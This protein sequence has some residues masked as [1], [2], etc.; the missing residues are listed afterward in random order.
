MKTKI[1][2]VSI[3]LIVFM[4]FL[5]KI[6]YFEQKNE[7]QLLNPKSTESN[8]SQSIP[9]NDN[10]EHNIKSSNKGKVLSKS[11]NRQ[12]VVDQTLKQFNS[13]L[14]DENFKQAGVVIEI[15]LMDGATNLFLPNYPVLLEYTYDNFEPESQTTTI[16]SLVTDSSGK[17][18]FTTNKIGKLKIALLTKDYALFYKNI[19]AG[20]GKNESKIKLYKGGT[21]EI[22]AVNE[23][24]EVINNLCIIPQDWV[25]VPQDSSQNTLVK[26]FNPLTFDSQKG[27]YT[28]TN[29]LGTNNVIFEAEGYIPSGLYQISVLANEKSFLE[30]KLQRPRKILLDFDLVDKPNQIKVFACTNVRNFDGKE[31]TQKEESSSKN[32]ILYK[33]SK[34]LYEYDVL[35]K[36]IVGLVVFVEGFIPKLLRLDSAISLY[37]LNLEKSFEGKIKVIN[38]NGLPISGANI[39]YFVAPHFEDDLYSFEQKNKFSSFNPVEFY[40][41][42]DEEGVAIVKNLKQQMNFT[43]CI[44]HNSYET[45]WTVQD[46]DFSQNNNFTITLTENWL[47]SGKIQ[48]HGKSVKGAKVFLYLK[49]D[50][51]ILLEQLETEESGDYRFSITKYGN[52]LPYIIKVYHFSHGVALTALE[53]KDI[54]K[55]VNINLEPEKSVTMKFIDE[56]GLPFSNKK[57][58]LMNLNLSSQYTFITNH[59]GEYEFYNLEHGNYL[60]GSLEPSHTTPDN[61]FITFSIPLKLLTVKLEKRALRKVTALLPDGKVYKGQLGVKA[62]DGFTIPLDFDYDKNGDRFIR[63]DFGFEAVYIFDAPGYAPIKFG[64]FNPTNSLP[65]EIKLELSEGTA[66]KVTVVDDLNNN[67]MPFVSI[68][69]SDDYGFS[70]TLPT[71]H[72]GEVVFTNL[73]S[74]YHVYAMENSYK[75][76][77]KDI[78]VLKENELEIKMVRCGKLIFSAA[79]RNAGS[80]ICIRHN[81]FPLILDANGKLEL[82]NLDPGNCSFTIEEWSENNLKDLPIGKGIE[83]NINIESNKTTEINLD[84]YLKK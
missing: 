15:I 34:N 48:K 67:P 46:F 62:F 61:N 49:E 26:N 20:Y 28:L 39:S 78:D 73:N 55:P 36:N 31:E 35:G 45:L 66:F 65:N 7:N 21:L 12:V 63:F 58:N 83:I 64:P 53:N 68:M 69:I 1:F 14:D 43:F 84:E 27:I 75:S 54:S 51:E 74:L 76:F 13:I 24:N 80:F 72:K 3:V 18:I 79:P 41:V 82:N 23:E 6:F 16:N 52:E 38:E 22:H 25:Y 33:N 59:Q 70:K 29:L 2:I 4:F 10:N 44:T 77:F 32:E 37:L 8:K 19:F 11:R 81:N 5:L 47:V 30:V 40:A 57:F 9:S 50:A 60:L 71:N 42:T 17:I 56:N